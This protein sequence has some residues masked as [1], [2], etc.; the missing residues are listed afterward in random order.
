MHKIVEFMLKMFFLF[1]TLRALA[2][3]ILYCFALYSNSAI[4]LWFILYCTLLY[5]II[6]FYTKF[7]LVYLT[8]KIYSR[9]LFGLSSF[10]R[11]FTE[12]DKVNWTRI[13]NWYWKIF[14]INLL[15]YDQWIL[16]GCGRFWIT[17]PYI[18]GFYSCMNYQ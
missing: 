1:L 5:C 18:I 3:V 8:R 12:M 2:S 10:C 11:K 7:R 14:K 9:D 6:V 4:L 13:L 17:F 16:C 15:F